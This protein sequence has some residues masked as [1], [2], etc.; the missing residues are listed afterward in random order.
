MSYSKK[1][2]IVSFSFLRRMTQVNFRRDRQ[3]LIPA[4]SA[5]WRGLLISACLFSVGL[6]QS[7]K[8]D[9]P[10]DECAFIDGLL[11]D[12][13]KD[14]QDA[15]ATSRK[16]KSAEYLDHPPPG[17]SECRIWNKLDL[18]CRW[19]YSKLS[20]EADMRQRADDLAQEIHSCLLRSKYRRGAWI[21]GTDASSYFVETGPLI[22]EVEAKTYSNASGRPFVEL[23]ISAYALLTEWQSTRKWYEEKPGEPKFSKLIRN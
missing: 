18:S 14:F 9:G 4:F 23:R 10:G 12:I 22:A 21:L 7:A 2:S 17:A 8:E 20:T 16:T 19:E 3:Q 13:A 6:A 5:V 11:V 15:H 1:M